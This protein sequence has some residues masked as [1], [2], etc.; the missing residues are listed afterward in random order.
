MTFLPIVG[1][2]LRVAARKRSTHFTRLGAVLIAILIGGFFGVGMQ[3]MS[4]PPYIV[5]KSLFGVLAVLSFIYCIGVG[6]L[7][8]SDCLSVEK[9]DGTMGLLFLTD[10]RGYD[11]VLGKLVANSLNAFYGMLAIFPVLA[12][13]LL[14]GGV[15][16]RE[17]ARVMLVCVNLM[18][19]SL[20]SGMFAS[21]VSREERKAMGLS[22]LILILLSAVPPL[23]GLYFSARTNWGSYPMAFLI[24]SPVY[25]CYFAF[26][27]KAAGIQDFFWWKI[28][29]T[30]GYAWLFL[31][32]SCFI[33]PRSWQES[34]SSTKTASWR[35][36]ARWIV[37]GSRENRDALRRRLLDTNAFLWL[38]GR[39]RGKTVVLW[40]FLLGLAVIW[41]WCWATFG[42]EWLNKGTYV[43]TAIFLHGILKYFMATE[44]CR[45]FVEDRRSG[46]LEL[47]LSTP[48]TVQEII[49]GQR[50]ALLRQFSGP[51][52]AVGII[53]C[54]F[55]ILGFNERNAYSSR[56]ETFW[57]VICL[58]GISIFIFDMIALGWVGM[59]LGMKSRGA[60][61]AT[62]GSLA[63]IV[64]L[65]WVIFAVSLMIFG[66]LSL[67]RS[68]S[69]E[70]YVFT[71]YWFAISVAINL[72]FMLLAKHNL[73]RKFLDI[74]TQRFD[75]KPLGPQK[76]TT[77]PPVLA[78]R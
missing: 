68:I 33:V 38:A 72:L 51:V 65:R 11:V 59:W 6:I 7:V 23:L 16:A 44:A 69:H 64:I 70:E 19:F 36:F 61:R 3:Q 37:E 75:F 48:L 12:V 34:S 28:A 47:L 5:G 20:A 49:R 39:G 67:F 60:N 45:R 35:G 76:K 57:A 8:T 10:L 78:T 46:A 50:L 63:R 30:H 74:A 2:E 52:L 4:A 73:N 32:L 17:F 22:I 15:T 54:L 1:R 26:V 29:L 62:L 53:D 14:L 56:E 41:L 13:P 77:L 71:L 9:R 21:S 31:V 42:K 58:V 66:W 27:P 55:L 18:F 43:F 40:S 25:D 24:P